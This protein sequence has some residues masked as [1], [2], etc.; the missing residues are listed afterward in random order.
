MLQLTCWF[1]VFPPRTQIRPVVYA[2]KDSSTYRKDHSADRLHYLTFHTFLFVCELT[3]KCLKK[4]TADLDEVR[5]RVKERVSDFWCR[6]QEFEKKKRYNP[7]MDF[8][9]LYYVLLSR[10]GF[11]PVG[12]FFVISDIYNAFQLILTDC[13][14]Q[15]RYLHIGFFFH[16]TSSVVEWTHHYAYSYRDFPLAV[17]D[18]QHFS[19]STL[20]VGKRRTGCI[21][22]I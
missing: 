10:G 17:A 5:P 19:E 21:G 2:D 7:F 18:M 22:H 11:L 3:G 8:I 6:N 15:Y 1:L 16:Q 9:L 4:L 20:S 14:C 13:Q 12:D